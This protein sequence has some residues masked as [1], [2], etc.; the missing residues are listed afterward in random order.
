MSKPDYYDVLGVDR[1]ATPD[2]VK[3]A[4]RKKAFEFHPDRN[5]DN[6]DAEE[7]FKL[8]AE[9]YDVLRDESKRERYDRF[10]H[11]GVNGNG[12]GGGGF[13]NA[14]DIFNSFSD[15]FGD[16]FGF[17]AGAR[18]SRG[19]RPT[20]GADLRYN[21]RIAF[22]Q[23]A[24][25]DTVSITIPK[26]VQCEECDGSGAAPGTSPEVCTLCNG[27][28][29][30]TRSQ[31]FFHVS[32]PCQTCRGTGQTISD[33]C[34]GCRG[35][36]IK[37][38][39]RELEVRIPA[40]VDNGSRLRL[41]GEGEPGEYGGPPGDLYVVLY[42]EEDKTFSRQG[43][44]LIYS[45]EI[46]MASASLG[47]SVEVPTLDDPENLTIPKGTQSGS[48][49]RLP[50]LGLPNPGRGGAGDLLVEVLVRTPEHLN[51]RQ[52]ELLREFMEI[53][54]GKMGNKV[55]GFFKKAKKAMGN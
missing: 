1:D 47:T 48:V 20:Q 28:G 37:Q 27:S 12:F 11:E 23:A 33:P 10:G 16:L 30:V 17:G 41:R 8:A 43:Q 7:Q 22:R 26:N 39:Q 42:V 51:K 45:L 55:K 4:Y 46:D 52:E 49:F 31:G 21:L 25:G 32:V 44:N 53:E 34:T 24:K 15:I 38:V 9:A 6:P 14:D 36:G 19:P 40:G 5:P 35:L 54:E 13:S 50:D 2:E 3:R 18:A 29:Q